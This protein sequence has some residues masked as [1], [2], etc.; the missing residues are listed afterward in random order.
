MKKGILKNCLLR[1]QR[2]PLVVVWWVFTIIWIVFFWRLRSQGPFSPAPWQAGLGGVFTLL[3]AITTL[4]LTYRSWFT[5]PKPRVLTIVMKVFFWI[6]G[7]GIIFIILGF[8]AL[9]VMR[10]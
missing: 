8:L 3:Y 6:W 7:G 2:R 10:K 4:F 5:N 1:L 9:F